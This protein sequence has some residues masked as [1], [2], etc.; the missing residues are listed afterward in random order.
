MA[1]RKVD[2]DLSKRAGELPRTAVERVITRVQN[3]RQYKIPDRFLHRQKDE[4]DVKYSLVLANGL[5]NQ[6]HKDLERLKKMRTHRELCHSWGLVG[7]QHT[8]TTDR[9]GRTVG[10]SKKK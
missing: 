4:K 8:K 10:V 9:R 2:T 1:L 7:G 6:L 5:D 3:P